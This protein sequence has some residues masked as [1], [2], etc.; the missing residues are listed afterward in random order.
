VN[1]ARRNR[2]LPAVRGGGHN[3]AGN[4]TRDDGIVID[5]SQR[6]ASVDADARRVTIEGGATLADVDSGT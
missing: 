5:L 4:A 2:P 1:F 3:I 6:A